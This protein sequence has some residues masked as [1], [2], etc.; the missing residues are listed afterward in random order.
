MSESSKTILLTFDVEDWFQVENFKNVIPR[1]HWETFEGRV[2]HSTLKI[3]DLLDGISTYGGS[4]KATFFILGWTAERYPNLVYEI[5]R[6]GHEIASHG[7]NHT[8]VPHMSDNE[9]KKDIAESKKL[10]EDLTGKSIKGYRAPSFSITPQLIEYLQ[11]AGYQYDSSYNSFDRHGRYGYISLKDAE[12]S[13]IAYR[14]T[15]SLIEIPISNLEIRGNILPWGGGG[16]FRLIPFS[17]FMEGVKTKLSKQNGFMF[18]AHPWE[19]DPQQPKIRNG[20][21]L[22]TRFRHYVNLKNTE[23]KLKRLITALS[24]C[25]FITC[26]EYLNSQYP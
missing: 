13:G 10:L 25:S 18:Y 11:E 1:S 26:I 20:L 14:L 22:L 7:Y 9:M 21:P 8:L 2:T 5:N 4:P 24:Q 12:K 23:K 15:S 16:Y 19:F 17:L 6:R 3:L